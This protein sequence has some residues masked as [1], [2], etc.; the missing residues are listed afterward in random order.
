[1]KNSL[2]F[3]CI[4]LSLPSFAQTF[5]FEKS[6]KRSSTE[7]NINY[8]K[9]AEQKLYSFDEQALFNHLKDN[10]GGDLTLDIDGKSHAL[11]FE[12]V[13][14]LHEDFMIYSNGQRNSGTQVSE[15]ILTYKVFSESDPGKES[16]FTITPNSIYG[17][18]NAKNDVISLLSRS[19]K[20]T[21]REVLIYKTSDLIIDESESHSCGADDK[22]I[23]KFEDS[24]QRSM[25]TGDLCKEINYT[26]SCD[27]EFYEQFA[28]KEQVIE[29]L[30]ALTNDMAPVYNNGQLG[31]DIF[32]NIIGI[33]VTDIDGMEPW[34]NDPDWWDAVNNFHDWA[35][36]FD[37]FEE[38]DLNSFITGIDNYNGDQS[39]GAT[40]VGTAP[41]DIGQLSS[42]PSNTNKY[43]SNYTKLSHILIHECGH[44][45]SASHNADTPSGRVMSRFVGHYA[46]VWCDAN[47]PG[48]DNVSLIQNL[49]ESS[50]ND[51]LECGLGEDYIFVNDNATGSNDGSSWE[52]AF[53]DLQDAIALDTDCNTSTKIL[54]AEGTYKPSSTNNPGQTFNLKNCVEIYGGFP[55]PTTGLSWWQNRDPENHPTI[56]TGEIGDPTTE[57][58]NSNHIVR[59]VYRNA[60]VVIDGF[61]FEKSKK[62]SIY[63]LALSIYDMDISI[64]NC[65]FEDINSS[66]AGAA[67][68]GQYTSGV[69]ISLSFDN[70]T[71]NNNTSPSNGGAIYLTAISV[72]T[73]V[74]VAISNSTFTNNF[75]GTSAGAIYSHASN[76]AVC[77]IDITGSNFTDN[78]E[79]NGSIT[80]SGG[81][82]YTYTLSNA[83]H[84]MNVHRSEFKNNAAKFG[85]AIR[86][87]SSTNFYGNVYNS[88]FSENNATIFG[89]DL[90][91][92]PYYINSVGVYN[93]Y[94]VT[95]FNSSGDHSFY[96][97]DANRAG[98]KQLNLYNSIVRGGTIRIDDKSSSVIENSL[99]TEAT[100]PN[101]S[102]CSGVLYNV[103]PLFVQEPDAP[104]NIAGD[105][106]LQAGSPVIN[107]EF[108]GLDLDFFNTARPAQGAYDWGAVET[109]QGDVK[110][111]Y[112]NDDVVSTVADGKTWETAFPTIHAAFAASAGNTFPYEI[113]VAEGTYSPGTA[114]GNTYNLTNNTT[115][116]GGFP[117][118]DLNNS[119][120]AQRNPDQFPTIL[121][122]EIGDPSTETDNTNYLF[123]CTYRNIE[124]VIDGFVLE[125]TQKSSIYVLEQTIYDL[126]MSIRNCTFQNISSTTAGGAFYGKFTG[127]VEA[128]LSFEN[129][130]FDGITSPSNG[131]AIYLSTISANTIVDVDITD[132]AFTDNFATSSGGAIYTFAQLGAECTLDITDSSFEGNGKSNGAT[133]AT[134]GAIYTYTLSNSQHTMNISRSKFTDNAANIG[135]A[136][137]SRSTTNFYGNIYNT[138]FNENTASKGN[139]LYQDPYHTN[140]VGV[141]NLYNVTSFN[142]SGTHS[143]YV[144]DGNLVGDKQLN[145]HNSIIWG[146]TILI[147][148]KT[149]SDINNSIIAEASC[150][151]FATCTSVLYNQD[152]MFVQESDVANGVAGDFSLQSGSPA[153]DA[154]SSGEAFDYLNTARPQ[155]ADFDMGA[156][157]SRDLVNDPIVDTDGDGI[158]DADDS[159]PEI[160][161]TL[162]FNGCVD[163]DGDNVADPYDCDPNDPLAFALDNCADCGGDNSS[164]ADSDGDG[165]TADVDPDDNDPCVPDPSHHYCLQDLDGD[166]YFEYE[167]PDDNDPCVPSVY[168]DLSGDCDGD[169]I[170]NGIESA[171]GTDPLDACDPDPFA[172]SSGDCD[173]DGYTNGAE[174]AANTDPTDPC[175][176][177]P[178][179][180]PSGDC[181]G[182][183]YTNG[184]EQADGT[185][186]LDPYDNA[187]ADDCNTLSSEDF[188]AGPYDWD[189]SNI[190]SSSIFG[191]DAAHISA[192]TPT[193]T[194]E[195]NPVDLSNAEFIEITF[196]VYMDNFPNGGHTAFNV[197]ISH[198]GGNSF[199]SFG[200]YLF[201]YPIHQNNIIYNATFS[202]S[203]SANFTNA[204]IIRFQPTNI[205]PNSFAVIDNIELVVCNVNSSIASEHEVEALSRNSISAGELTVIPNPAVDQ[206]RLQADKNIVT[207]KIFDMTGNQILDLSKQDLNDQSS[208]RLTDYP[209]GTY[210]VRVMYEDGASDITRFV[211]VR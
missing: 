42:T 46:P 195:S 3:L 83:Q 156:M 159:C 137:R 190:I 165:H 41:G 130:V 133:T 141:Y 19:D 194:L 25:P 144:N 49:L 132:C 1:M 56:L 78:G 81:A 146:G 65:T 181:D 118:P 127:A 55:E 26:L 178:F 91:Q 35:D 110:I 138:I 205:I 121:T 149:S 99:I 97:E 154:T 30:I 182:D 33:C 37:G 11:K 98:N 111:Y 72:N 201:F 38:S 169:G 148:G 187:G 60:T 202:Y 125:K 172:V 88:I 7:L 209:T 122:G 32:F 61:K 104:N 180:I 136:L 158:A 87:R 204:D 15:Q 145:F 17:K 92:D 107:K 4:L 168:A 53:T 74:D 58:D 206:I 193:H 186:P 59:C 84:T 207:A 197:E 100:C 113:W 191:S 70:C 5:S 106:S 24:T 79:S 188:E 48:Y 6:Q 34:G 117:N 189:A 76:S 163:T 150:P 170:S 153:L 31:I 54:V 200:T 177:D 21:D 89:N 51:D 183:G 20:V 85:G 167:D 140:C 94:N 176:P 23:K 173:D 45:F 161:G 13:D 101:N 12:P 57:A 69:E 211:I 52:N 152:P 47:D 203:G 90:Y 10:N 102:T 199:T 119:S 123:R 115:L 71:F 185:D 8:V 112:V 75:A 198:D 171:N 66:S 192:V 22:V 39:N 143:Y 63:T 196:D 29:T 82:I 50:N 175:D 129:C 14:I 62:S 116:L 80:P 162:E 120:L 44:N 155:F 147:D 128:S 210:L 64:R 135:G 9:D 157:E 40:I 18:I 114:P 103:D 95:S 16:R 109:T 160:A 27:Y 2:V 67:Y 93:L 166:G 108:T 174:Q 142:T 151:T 208:I 139:D 77:N 124:V 184:Q 86:S 131:G 43:L 134:G 28:T 179:A 36:G 73:Q 105:F 96:V 164:C 68:Y 126:D